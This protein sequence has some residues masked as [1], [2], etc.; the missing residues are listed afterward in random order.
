[1]AA[2][3]IAARLQPYLIQGGNE[4]ADPTSYQTCALARVEQQLGAGAFTDA[5]L[6]QYYALY[7][8]Y[9]ATNAQPN[10]I[11]DADPNFA[12][13][14]TFPGW[15][16][17]DGWTASDIDPCTGGWYGIVC[18]NDQV[19]EVNLF[20]NLLTGIWP[21]EITML[22]SD[23]PRATGAGA[24]T[25]IDL[26]ANEFLFNNFDNSWISQLGSAMSFLYFQETAFAG[27]LVPLPVN[28]FEFDCSYTLIDG[29]LTDATFAGLT[30]L[31]WALMDGNAYNSSVPSV[32]GSLPELE[33]LYLSD[34]FI[35]GDLSY[36]QGMPKI[37]EHWIDFNPGL[38]GTIP[39][40]IGALS[41]LQSLS[42]AVT[43]LI[44]P[45]PTEL[46]NLPNLVQMWLFGNNLTGT[47][48]SQLALPPTLTILQLEENALVGTMPA[49]ICQRRQFPG[50]LSVLGADCQE[51]SCTPGT[52]CTCCSLLEC[53][54]TLFE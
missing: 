51:V 24:L 50:T 18:V 6:T 11:T 5:K 14:T 49:E 26:F 54:P 43:N 4:F 41:T 52:C 44:G 37:N 33:Y 29:G 32:L 20:E 19:T 3:T 28:L 35:S 25:Q 21:A 13:I 31:N 53:N 23:G 39:T 45:I 7:C 30:K 10:L 15:T 27:P 8:I 12:N 1:M 22:A 38:T 47:I 16:R 2:S 17:S 48:P 36:M 46:G 42:V 34:S 9:C 40:S